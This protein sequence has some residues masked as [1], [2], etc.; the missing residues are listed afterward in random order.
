MHTRAERRFN[1][2]VKV[3][4]R[5]KKILMDKYGFSL[6]QAEK[7]HP[8]KDK[9]HCSCDIC[10]AKTNT[11]RRG[12]LNSG[13]KLSDVKKLIKESEGNYEFRFKKLNRFKTRCLQ[14]HSYNWD[15]KN[16]SLFES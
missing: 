5:R 13:Y 3:A 15:F 14:V 9:V 2:S 7:W 6:E 8:S 4:Y 10:A 11:K 16:G 12:L 1:T